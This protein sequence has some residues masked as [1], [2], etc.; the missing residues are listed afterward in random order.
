MLPRVLDLTGNRKKRPPVCPV[1]RAMAD[2][3]KAPANLI[4]PP[5]GLSNQ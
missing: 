1:T 5:I 3:G 2:A 4:L